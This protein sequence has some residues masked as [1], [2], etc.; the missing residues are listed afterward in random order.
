MVGDIVAVVMGDT[1]GD[2]A[3]DLDHALIS[4]HSHSAFV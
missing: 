1:G 2:M 3:G 4:K